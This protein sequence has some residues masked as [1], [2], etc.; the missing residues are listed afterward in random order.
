MQQFNAQPSTAG[1][2]YPVVANVETVLA[3]FNLYLAKGGLHVNLQGSAVFDSA[4]D[5]T[6]KCSF[7]LSQEPALAKQRAHQLTLSLTREEAIAE[8]KYLATLGYEAEVVN[9]PTKISHIDD[10]YRYTFNFTRRAKKA[11]QSMTR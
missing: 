4:I 3:Q 10:H 2:I 9:C 7:T 1:T 6:F 8:V 11:C 5:R